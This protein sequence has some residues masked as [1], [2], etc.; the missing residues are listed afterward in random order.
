[1][2]QVSDRGRTRLLAAYVERTG[3]V[4]AAAFGDQA[5]PVVRAEQRP[6]RDGADVGA[7]LLHLLGGVPDLDQPAQLVFAVGVDVGFGDR[8]RQAVAVPGFLQQRADARGRRGQH[9]RAFDVAV[10]PAAIRAAAVFR[11]AFDAVV[12]PA[13]AGDVVVDAHDVGRAAVVLEPEQ[14]FRARFGGEQVIP[15][16]MLL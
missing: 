4:V 14:F 11:I 15:Q 5:V 9:A 2:H 7:T 13:F 10:R 3:F 12:E 6:D 16:R 1:A 8:D